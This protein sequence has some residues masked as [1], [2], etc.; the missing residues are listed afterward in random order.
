MAKYLTPEALENFKKELDYL[1]NTKR[2]EIGE[3]IKHAA[4]FGDLKENAAY[5][6]AKEA[7]AFL[8]GRILE[9]KE[10]VSQAKT[11]EKKNSD[12]VQIGS[13]VLIVSC[14]NEEKF[15]IVEPEEASAMSGKISYKSPLG[16]TLLG[17]CAGEKIKLETPG[18]KSE[19]KILKII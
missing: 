12:K 11:I 2:K 1:Q 5:H 16:E 3:R 19:Y 15:Q 17:K 8:E 18:G 6:E 9:L 7:Q 14:G 4:S 10:I 13:V